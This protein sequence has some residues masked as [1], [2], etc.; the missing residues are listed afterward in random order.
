MYT[1]NKKLI[2]IMIVLNYLDKVLH[3]VKNNLNSTS[4]FLKDALS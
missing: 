4:Y 2:N 3:E 1:W